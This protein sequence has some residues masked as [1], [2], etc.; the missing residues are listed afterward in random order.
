MTLCGL[1]NKVV[2]TISLCKFGQNS[3]IPSWDRQAKFSKSK[4]KM[5]PRS[6]K[7]N[8][9]LSLSQQYSC[10]SSVKIKIHPFI[11]ETGCRQAIFQQSKPLRDLENKVKVTRM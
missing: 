8:Q 2:T 11:Q 5:G 9:F 4:P 1:E 10:A 6:P 7:S 3:S